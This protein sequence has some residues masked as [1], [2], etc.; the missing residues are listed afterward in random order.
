MYFSQHTSTHVNTLYRAPWLQFKTLQRH[1]I[2]SSYYGLTRYPS[3]LALPTC[4]PP[5]HQHSFNPTWVSHSEP[6]CFCCSLSLECFL[7][8]LCSFFQAPTHASKFDLNV[9]SLESPSPDLTQVT[10]IPQR[11]SLSQ[12]LACFFQSSCHKNP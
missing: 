6:L 2:S 4:P 7:P 5:S 8:F 12:S 9:I 1:L 10:L 11:Y 3:G